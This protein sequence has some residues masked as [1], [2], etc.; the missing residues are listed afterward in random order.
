MR[1]AGEETIVRLGGVNVTLRPTL[2]AAIRLERRYGFDALFRNVQEMNLSVICDLVRESAIE[3][4]EQ[5]EHALAWAPLV[6]VAELI[7]PLL[8]HVIALTGIDAETI[9]K[10][11]GQGK[12]A[13]RMTLAEHL[14][15]LFE[16]GTGWLGYSPEVTLACTPREL[17]AA[18]K[19]R[20][21]MLKAIF[22]G[23]DESK[24]NLS[25]DEKINLAV[26]SMAGQG[27]A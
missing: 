14:R 10:A 19:G 4:G 12:D 23:S 18:H 2:R 5:F 21:D 6:T 1:I 26:A 20:A 27:R 22:G 3:N 15:K 7:E 17:L 24:P 8:A 9:G 16:I 11:T 25:L 13:P